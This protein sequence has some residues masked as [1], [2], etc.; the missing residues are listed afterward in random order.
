MRFEWNGLEGVRIV[1]VNEAEKKFLPL[2]MRGEATDER[3]WEWLRH[4]ILPKHRQYVH[5]TLEK[6]GIEYNVRS[7][8]TV[9]KGLSLN[10][11]HWVT[12]DKDKSTWTKV[13][14]YDNPFSEILARMAFT[15][16]GPG[17]Y[18]RPKKVDLPKE[19]SPEFTTN[20]MLAKCWRRVDG[21][22]TSTSP[23]PRAR[24]TRASSRIRNTMRHRSPRRWDCR[25][26][27]TDLR[28][29]RA[30]FARRVRF[31]QTRNTV[32]SPP[33]ARWAEKRH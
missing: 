5:Y 21:Q 23:A 25:M 18:S 2:E 6:L 3:L 24:R 9:S 8:I 20:G 16:M 10:D 7:I 31:S 33:V 32:S 14:L 13:N 26:L 17:D 12:D 29:S 30:A 19:T 28:I 11:V 4:R 1:S 15:G 27:N 22:I